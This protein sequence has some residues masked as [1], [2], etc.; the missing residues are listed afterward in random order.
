MKLNATEYTCVPNYSWI[1]V[2]KVHLVYLTKAKYYF[3]VIYINA[4]L[5]STPTNWY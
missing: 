3:I 1:L 4:N 2:Y 5:L